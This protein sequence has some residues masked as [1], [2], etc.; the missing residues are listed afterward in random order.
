M[1]KEVEERSPE[2]ITIGTVAGNCKLS[3][4]TVSRWIE[5]GYLIALRLSEG[6]HRTHRDDFAK[7]LAKHDMP[8]HK[9]SNS[10]KIGGERCEFKIYR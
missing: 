3:K 2:Y 4:V 7:F 9:V 1:V 5:K 10:G 6:H 8:G